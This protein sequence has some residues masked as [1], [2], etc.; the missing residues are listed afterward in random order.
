MTLQSKYEG[1][2]WSV[3]NNFNHDNA[4]INNNMIACFKMEDGY[5]I[6]NGVIKYFN[7]DCYKNF[8][9]FFN[10]FSLHTSTLKVSTVYNQ[11]NKYVSENGG[12]QRPWMWS[13][14]SFIADNWIGGNE[15]TM[16]GLL[17]YTCIIIIQIDY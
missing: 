15:Y 7:P 5:C 9:R 17:A 4:D 16:N 10:W 2:W 11:S 8:T 3:D 13:I 1:S 12:I 14:E 6:K